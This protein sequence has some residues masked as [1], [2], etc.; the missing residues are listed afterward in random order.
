[1]PKSSQ[2]EASLW[3]PCGLYWACWFCWCWPTFS[4]LTGCSQLPEGFRGVEDWERLWERL[5]QRNYSEALLRALFFEN[6]MRVVSEV[7]T[8]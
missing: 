8:M 2:K 3:T 7:C 6:L 5:L 4:S 1:M